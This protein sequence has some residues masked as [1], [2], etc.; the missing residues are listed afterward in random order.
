MIIVWIFRL[1]TFPK[2]E[3]ATLAHVEAEVIAANRL[4]MTKMNTRDAQ[5]SVARQ[6]LRQGTQRD[7]RGSGK[8]VVLAANVAEAILGRRFWLVCKCVA[9]K[10]KAASRWS[11]ITTLYTN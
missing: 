5:K 10:Y 4:I 11:I 2:S 9:E 1:R 8:H 7:E 3:S 6:R